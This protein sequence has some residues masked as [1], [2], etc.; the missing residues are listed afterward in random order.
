MRETLLLAIVLAASVANASAA[1]GTRF[2]YD[3]RGRVV[4]SVGRLQ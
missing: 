2:L 4:G 1:E 3:V